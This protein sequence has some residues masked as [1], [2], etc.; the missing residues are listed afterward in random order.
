M[1]YV[2]KRLFQK[3]PKVLIGERVESPPTFSPAAD[4]TKIP[5]Y[6][7][8]VARRRSAH[9]YRLRKLTHRKLVRTKKGKQNTYARWA[10]QGSHQGRHPLVYPLYPFRSKNI[11]RFQ[12][13]NVRW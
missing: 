12:E 10:C 6:T 4:Q 2:V 8:L 3:H 5:Q 13:P 9:P 1:I 7:E 11:S